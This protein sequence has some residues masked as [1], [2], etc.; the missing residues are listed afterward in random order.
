MAVY[1][2][3]TV[4]SDIVYTFQEVIMQPCM[5]HHCCKVLYHYTAKQSSYNHW[6]T[7]IIENIMEDRISS[8]VRSLHMWVY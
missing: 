8:E 4:L 3:R 6:T 2:Y 7:W 5:Q 1:N